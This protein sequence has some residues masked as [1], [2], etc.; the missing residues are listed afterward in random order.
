MVNTY[1]KRKDQN[2][3]QVAQ[4]KKLNKKQG[5]LRQENIKL[6]ANQVQKT[7]NFITSETT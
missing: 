6:D 7:Q 2:P 5:V 1:M 4:D 3:H